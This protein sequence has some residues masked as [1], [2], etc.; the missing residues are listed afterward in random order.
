[1]SGPKTGILRLTIL[2]CGSSGGV[3]RAT[4][5]WGACDPNEPK[6]RR[7]R[8]ALLVQKWEGEEAGDPK[9]ATVVLVDTP[10]DLRHQLARER[11]HHIDAVLFSHDHADQT[12]GIDDVRAYFLK[13]MRPIPCFMDAPTRALIA[14]RFAYCFAE[15]PGYPPILKIAG[16]LEP[17]MPMTIDGPGGPLEVLPLLQDH[18]FSISLGFRFGAAAYTND[19]V[20][21]PT[22]TFEALRGLDLWVVDALREKPHPTH[23]HI[24]R[25][26]EW[27]AELK[28]RH[29][30]LTNL[31]HDVDYATLKA[32]LEAQV[33][34]A[35]EPAYDG[36]SAD[37]AI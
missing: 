9:D 2:G 19:V 27:I 36:F 22:E 31:N 23:A 12:H 29:A 18:G 10:P 37:V 3:P 21:F 25:T 34:G 7:T 15:T 35:V 33:G 11:P 13:S 30:V 20:A 16:E 6:N 32:R 14:P 4:G 26:L 8:G 17:L 1:M 5:D 24:D 28:P